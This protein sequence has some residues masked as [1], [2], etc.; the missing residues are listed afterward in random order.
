MRLTLDFQAQSFLDEGAQ[1]A[2]FLD[3]RVSY[4][5]FFHKYGS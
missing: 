1:K 4:E 2:K 5:A 3:Y